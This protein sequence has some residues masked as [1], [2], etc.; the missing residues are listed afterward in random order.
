MPNADDFARL[1]ESGSVSGG[2]YYYAFQCVVCNRVYEGENASTRARSCCRRQKP[3]SKKN[4]ALWAAM[5]QADGI[6]ARS[7]H[8]PTPRTPHA[9][10]PW[11]KDRW[12][13]RYRGDDPALKARADYFRA[14][15]AIARN[16]D[17]EVIAWLDQVAPPPDKRHVWTALQKL[18]Y[19]YKIK[20]WDVMLA[21]YH[22]G[23]EQAAKDALQDHGIP[24]E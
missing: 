8:Q 9:D 7:Y 19:G 14:V 6:L 20:N 13:H 5:Q 12:M 21:A 17:R 3:L 18:A 22:E 4:P 2:D 15:D 23:C 24:P 16:Y 1:I 10:E 11:L